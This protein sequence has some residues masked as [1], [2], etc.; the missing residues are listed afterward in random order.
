MADL[1]ATSFRGMGAQRSTQPLRSPAY[2]Y[3]RQ[4]DQVPELYASEAAAVAQATSVD[5]LALVKLFDPCGAGT[6]YVAEYDP[7]TRVAFGVAVI[8]E[9]EMGS[10]SMAELVEFRGR[11]G[12]PIERDL[13]WRQRPLSECA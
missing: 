2:R 13:H 11:F 9:R 1:E 3:I 7:E 10:F 8:H 4:A 5:P 12:L 6:W